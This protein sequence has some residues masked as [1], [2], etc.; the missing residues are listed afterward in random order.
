MDEDLIQEVKDSPGQGLKT[1][2]SVGALLP[3]RV[4]LALKVD[5]I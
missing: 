4:P 1:I 3:G 5:H 2:W